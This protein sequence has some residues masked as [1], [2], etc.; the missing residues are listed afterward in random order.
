MP[1][2]HDEPRDA[3]LALACAKKIAAEAQDKGE[4]QTSPQKR[5][6]R[7]PLQRHSSLPVL[8]MATPVSCD[9]DSSS[10]LPFAHA[11]PLAHS[12][13]SKLN[14]VGPSFAPYSAPDPSEVMESVSM[15]K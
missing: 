1:G 5:K 15:Y 6:S 12:M 7:R 11:L 14:Q 8:V 4:K 10:R 13:P 2:L 9:A 3:A